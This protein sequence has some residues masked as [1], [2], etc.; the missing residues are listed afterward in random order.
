MYLHCDLPSQATF[1][2]TVSGWE[3]ALSVCPHVLSALDPLQRV[4]KCHS[5]LCVPSLSMHSQCFHPL[6]AS[7]NCVASAK[8]SSGGSVHLIMITACLAAGKMGAHIRYALWDSLIVA[9]T[10]SHIFALINDSHQEP[11]D[12]R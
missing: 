6:G 12:E 2:C 1:L 4:Q 3:G 7:D 11:T 5:E 8:P 10:T 9:S